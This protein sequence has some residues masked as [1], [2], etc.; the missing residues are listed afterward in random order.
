MAALLRICAEG[1]SVALQLRWF[2][3]RRA[4]PSGPELVDAEMVELS[5]CGTG[6]GRGTSWQVIQQKALSAPSGKAITAD[7][8]LIPAH[9]SDTAALRDEIDRLALDAAELRTQR[10]LGALPR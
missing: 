6:V 4:T 7:G 3:V 2:V 5:I 8:L 10:L 9:E 1:I